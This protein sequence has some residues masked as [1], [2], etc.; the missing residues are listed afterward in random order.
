MPA[1]VKTAPSGKTGPFLLDYYPPYVEKE[2]GDICKDAI[3]DFCAD[4]G[5]KLLS[6]DYE[7]DED[8]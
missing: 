6:F 8:Y 3:N 1:D 5:L 7:G 2:Y 4:Y